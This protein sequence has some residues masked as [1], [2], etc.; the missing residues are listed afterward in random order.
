MPVLALK[1]A[2]LPSLLLTQRT[3][4][5]LMIES[6]WGPLLLG[7]A[8]SGDEIRRHTPIGKGLHTHTHR[9]TDGGCNWFPVCLRRLSPSGRPNKN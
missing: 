4:L 6:E 2:A 8:G 7:A 3:G 9:Q 1:G 5:R